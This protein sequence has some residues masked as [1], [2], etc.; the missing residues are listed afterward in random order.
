MSIGLSAIH[1]VQVCKA[2]SF[3]FWFLLMPPIKFRPPKP[4]QFR[5]PRAAIPELEQKPIIHMGKTLIAQEAKRIKA[6]HLEEARKILRRKLGKGKE[7]NMLVHATYPV[8]N[9][10][11]GTKR[12]KGKGEIAYHVARVPVGGALFQI[13]G[14]PGLPGLAPDYKGFSGI[15]GRFPINCQYRNQTNNFKMDRVCAEVPA[16][17]QV[18]K[19]RR[20]VKSFKAESVCSGGGVPAH[21]GPI[22]D[23]THNMDGNELLQMNLR[24]MFEDRIL[25]DFTIVCTCSEPGGSGEIKAHSVILAAHSGV[26]RQQLCQPRATNKLEIHQKLSVMRALVR[27]MY[28]GGLAPDDDPTSLSA[29]DMLSVLAEARN[30][31]IEAL[32]EDMVAQVILPKLDPH[33]CLSILL[34]PSLSSHSTISREVSAYVGQQLPRLLHTDALRKQLLDGHLSQFA[35]AHV[36]G[37]ASQAIATDLDCESVVRFV[38]EWAGLD[39]ICDLLRQCKS[40]QEW[41]QAAAAR[42]GKF[43]EI[44]TLPGY[45]PA[46][47][48]ASAHEWY[49]PSLRAL[50]PDTPGGSAESGDAVR[51][52][53]GQFFSWVVRLDR[54]DEGRIRIVYE[55]A[56]LRLPVKSSFAE[57]LCVKRFPAAQFQWE[58]SAVSVPSGAAPGRSRPPH[59]QW[60]TVMNSDRPPVFICFPSGVNLH[61]STTIPIGVPPGEDVALSVRA[62]LVEIPLVSL[63]LYYFSADLNTTVRSEDILNRLPHMEF[64]CVSSFSLFQQQLVAGGGAAAGGGPSLGGTTNLSNLSAMKSHD[65]YLYFSRDSSPINTSPGMTDWLRIR[66]AALFLAVMMVSASVDRDCERDGMDCVSSLTDTVSAQFTRAKVDLAPTRAQDVDLD[67]AKKPGFFS[68]DMKEM[69]KRRDRSQTQSELDSEGQTIFGMNLD[70]CVDTLEGAVGR[71]KVF[72]GQVISVENNVVQS[73]SRVRAVVDLSKVVDKEGSTFHLEIDKLFDLYNNVAV[74]ANTLEKWMADEKTVRDHLSSVYRIL[75]AKSVQQEGELEEMRV[76]LSNA[77]KKMQ[78]IHSHVSK[79]L[80]AVANAETAMYEWAYN[81]TVKVNAQTTKIVNLAQGMEYR[82]A[83]IDNAEIEMARMANLLLSLARHF[84]DG[85]ITDAAEQMVVHTSEEKLRAH[86]KGSGSMADGPSLSDIATALGGGTDILAAPSRKS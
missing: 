10:V 63:I 80:T 86:R 82:I 2:G 1:A 60:Q 85:D 12:G 74:R 59:H 5:V 33:N 66:S 49:I 3:Y 47:S 45:A 71:Y 32:T 23:A 29:A 25:T 4:V 41:R 79:V 52:I 67:Q 9:R 26:L 76:I 42:G 37:P 77:V 78:G 11:E 43:A 14:V 22:E 55:S 21:I 84:H 48:T 38:T 27:F 7:F 40:W 51:V 39:S 81:V 30:L 36:L 44:D 54:A 19:W 46:D 13:P 18:A 73:E 17:V 68:K 70:T 50:L 35:M 72:E 6:E 62:N 69:L 16:R 28:F 56:D 58:V 57:R 53:K 75:Q 83:Q 24:R 61:W 20:Q 65:H 15:Q 31:G 34:H 8:T 64:R